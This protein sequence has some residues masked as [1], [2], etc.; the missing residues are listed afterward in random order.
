M[1]CL[2]WKSTRVSG[3]FKA[4]AATGL[5][6]AFVGVLP[7]H[8]ETGQQTMVSVVPQSTTVLRTLTG[9][10]RI[11]L[12]NAGNLLRF[13]GPTGYDHVGVGELSEGYVLCY[14]GLIAYDTGSSQ[15][16]FGPPTASC[17]SGTSCTVTRTT[18]DGRMRLRQVISKTA[19]ER[20]L[21]IEMTLTKL[22]S[23]SVT[24][25]VLR[26]QVDFDV[27]TG[28]PAGSGDFT[29]WFGAT[30]RDS[31]F[32]WNAANTTAGEGH[33]VVLRHLR[34]S[35]TSVQYNAKVTSN[36]LDTSCSPGNVAANG[37]VNGDYGATI[38]YNVGTM[39]QGAV[40]TGI[41]Q[42]ERN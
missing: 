12:S 19:P 4:V 26:R 10:P 15:V 17:S 21:D 23:G 9:T 2:A 37:P 36:I 41:V 38:Q 31:A 16:G 5:I 35:P 1:S 33:S 34:R 30:E 20:S 14:S 8:A 27:D 24:G 11:T 40:F 22:G 3:S 25:V 32:A 29:N 7:A 6:G 42:Y 13:E 28:G 39:G 18:T